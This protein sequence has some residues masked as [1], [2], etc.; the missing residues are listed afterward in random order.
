MNSGID[1]KVIDA[2]SS[3]TFCVM[4]STEAAGMNAIMNTVATAP[5]AKAIG[6]PANM[7]TR[8]AA[9]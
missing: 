5:S 7:A 2:I 4:V 9:P 1:S 6:I 8:V 3:Y